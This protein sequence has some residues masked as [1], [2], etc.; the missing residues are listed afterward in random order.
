MNKPSTQVRGR[1]GGTQDAPAQSR[2]VV[3]PRQPPQPPAESGWRPFR[4]KSLERVSRAQAM[5]TQR[6]EWLMPASTGEVV[7]GI[8]SRIK[9]LLEDEM[10]LILDYVHVIRPGQMKKLVGE[11]TFLAVLAPAPQKTRGFLEIELGLAHAAID[12]LLGG[13]GETVGHRPLTD[14]EEGVISFI[15]LEALK[16][17]APNLEPGLP[18]LR[19]EGTA[20]SVDE[21]M[22]MLG[23]ES[24]VV[25]TQFK[26]T[27]GAQAGFIRLFVPATIVGLTNPPQGGGPERRARRSAEVARNSSRLSSVKT[28]LR[29]EIGRAEVLGRDL[30][31]LR[32]GDVVLVDEIT[33]RPDRGEGGTALLRLGR[34][35]AGWI[36]SEVVVELERYRAKLTRF[37]LGEPPHVAQDPDEQAAQQA[38]GDEQASELEAGVDQEPRP[39]EEITN[40]AIHG[41]NE[42]VSDNAEGVDLLN[43]IPLQVA[44]ELARIPISAEEVVGLKVGQVIDLNRVPGEPVEMSVN[45]K[46]V[47]R[48]ELVEIEGH[49]GVR[50]L[51][52]IG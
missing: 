22:V 24:Q 23:D 42:H 3:P 4:F 52:L 41:E 44:V 16:T 12:K 8:T 29:A 20:R 38:A 36:E 18:R 10:K 33:A 5:L 47:A 27:L 35:R 39:R 32:A 49:L 13:A 34:G 46:V 7:E 30:Q 19:L 37:V 2:Y 1:P 21:A 45:G 48:G 28:W 43:D 14:I 51:S 6:L 31:G 9:D 11:P 15:I 26:G 50:I 40:P 17:L 25:V